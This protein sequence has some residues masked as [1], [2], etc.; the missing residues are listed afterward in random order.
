MIRETL[1]NELLTLARGLCE[2]RDCALAIDCAVKA[3]AL[4]P[5]CAEARNLIEMAV[6]TSPG[7]PED[8]GQLQYLRHRKAKVEA[9]L[10]TDPGLA[11]LLGV[12]FAAL[13]PPGAVKPEAPS[14]D[15]DLLRQRLE[16]A[17]R[18]M[19]RIKEGQRRELR[20]RI[21]SLLG[22]LALAGG[23]PVG[24]GRNPAQDEFE[25][26]DDLSLDHQLHNIGNDF[27]KASRFHE[28]V[29]CYSLALQLVPDLLESFFNRGLTQTRLGNYAKAWEDLTAVVRL[30]PNLAEAWYTRGLIE[31]YRC[32][33]EAAVADYD[34]A[35]SVDGNYEKARTQR[36]VARKKQ[37]DLTA[38]PT[39]STPASAS[40]ASASGSLDKD[41]RMVDFSAYRQKSDC[42]FGDVCNREARSRLEMVAAYLK[43]ESAFEDWGAELPRGVMLFGPP[44]TGKT[45]LAR[46]LAGEVDCPFYCVPST[47]F[48]NLYYGNTEANL[49]HFWH[50]ASSHPEGSVVFMDEFDVIGSIRN[51]VNTLDGDRCHDRTVGCLLELMDGFSRLKNRMVVIAATNALHNV[52]PAFL[53]SGRFD[54][55]IQVPPPTAEEAVEILRI[56]LRKA[57]Q[58]AKRL[59]FLAPDL[60]RWVRG[61]GAFGRER[62]P[63]RPVLEPP[64]IAELAAVAVRH[65]L[66]GADLNEVVKRT[67][68]ERA[69]RQIRRETSCGAIGA[70]DLRPHFEVVL[71]EKQKQRSHQAGPA[72]KTALAVN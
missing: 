58:R 8:P 4:S 2:Q 60:Q 19:V 14:L 72:L 10:R 56:H 71:K 20:S 33:F 21:E 18:R 35:L 40:A 63:D 70:D 47:A 31:E 46:A 59:D 26:G 13:P 68:F 32:N 64:G 69:A 61:A 44:G 11:M 1:T 43:G 45:L 52:D 41:G 5:D 7:Q 28:A 9:H 29:E 57:E 38:A 6:N 48:I 34:R 66:V 30:N 50:Q 3:L 37:Q 23:K 65:Q 51:Q 25:L 27:Y 36:E 24:R 49:R 22:A 16:S 42:R 15:G 62:L 67:V 53:R 55:L 39:E 17:R 12:G 54:F